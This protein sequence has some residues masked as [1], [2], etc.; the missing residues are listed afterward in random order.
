MGDDELDLVRVLPGGQESRSLVRP[1][2]GTRLVVA[3]GDGTEEQAEGTPMYG[4]LDEME[5]G[6]VIVQ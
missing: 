4:C 3:R 6:G 2:A 5:P 1:R